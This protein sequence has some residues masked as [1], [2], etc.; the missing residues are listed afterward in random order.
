MRLRSDRKQ[1]L[2]AAISSGVRCHQWRKEFYAAYPGKTK[3]RAHQAR[4][5]NRRLMTAEQKTGGGLVK[6]VRRC[7]STP[8]PGRR[9]QR[10]ASACSPAVDA[11]RRALRSK[12]RRR[13]G[14]PRLRRAL[15]ELGRHLVERLCNIRRQ[16]AGCRSVCCH[17]KAAPEEDRH[18]QAPM[19]SNSNSPNLV[20][21]PVRAC[22]DFTRFAA[23]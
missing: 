17:R 22:K 14:L 2:I 9:R 11:P 5:P 12:G 4:C 15:H 23:P 6:S 18:K 19:H 16:L 21:T 1:S 10:A 7:G 8:M 20:S 13:S 3:R